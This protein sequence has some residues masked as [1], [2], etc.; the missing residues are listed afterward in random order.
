MRRIVVGGIV[1]VALVIAGC[2]SVGGTS[3]A[4]SPATEA[5]SAPATPTTPVTPSSAAHDAEAA[6]AD[7][8]MPSAAGPVIA[9]GMLLDDGTPMLCFNV[10]T[11]LP[12]QCGGP[13]VVEWDWTGVPFEEASG[14]RWADGVALEGTYDAS[15]F[16]IAPAGPP[17]DLAAITLP[18]RE[19]P[20]GELSDAQLAAIQ[21]DV[22]TLERPDIMGHGG[23]DGTYAID[24]VFDDGAMQAAF[25]EIYGPGA[26]YVHSW[27]IG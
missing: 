24:V 22:L 13:E 12:P 11:S 20:V 10:A 1:A 15:S 3:P 16:S 21:A 26:V 25:D 19:V 27:F 23:E 9:V 14:V 7:L 6:L 2:S 18:A 4:A 8:P 5:P 17:L